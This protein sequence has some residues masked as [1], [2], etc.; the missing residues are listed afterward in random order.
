MEAEIVKA[1]QDGLQAKVDA[2]KTEMVKNTISKED[3]AAKMAELNTS[4]KDAGDAAAKIDTELKE[5]INAFNEKLELLKLTEKKAERFVDDVMKQAGAAI[6]AFKEKGKAAIDF[7]TKSAPTAIS[8]GTSVSTSAGIPFEDRTP[9]IS[10]APE[11]APLMLDLILTGSTNSD[12]VTW[13]EKTDEAG[14]PAFKK[15]F[16]EFPKRS[17][18][19]TLRTTLVKKI[20][21]L[22]EY[23]NEIL[24]DVD[25][26]AAELRRDLVEQ[27]Q[28][29]LDT[30]ILNGEGG[31]ASD[32]DLKGILDY[33][34]AW[35][36]GTF[37]VADPTIYDV[38]AVAVN[39][40]REEHHNPTVIVMRPSTAMQ[41]KLS[42]DKNGNYVMPPF[43]AANG[44]NVEGLPVV[45][46]TLLGTGEILVMDGTK[47]QFLWK[48]NWRLEVSD[49]H[50]E[51]FSKDVVAVRL[52]GRGALK[53]KNTDAK[54]FVHIA[55]VADAI[56]AL[57][58]GS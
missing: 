58:P 46:N 44:V 50:D 49:S 37:T 2:L 28:L 10:Y 18:K 53:I 4:I 12:T 30:N 22:A 13:V 14:A 7:V 25:Y 27:I 23:S 39:Q 33:A 32:A 26:F 51:N 54:A 8:M 19:S 29:A 31:G 55:D 48:R 1:I 17:W 42:K 11:R 20:A 6:K 38:L 3:F 16:E 40:I 15:E 41:M 21:V 57:T 5:T 47:A 56:E 35:N 45:T 24:E 34:Q 52:S 9:G 36:N 43:A